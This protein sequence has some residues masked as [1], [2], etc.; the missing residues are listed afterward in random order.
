M[1]TTNDIAMVAPALEKYAQGP[2]AD[3]IQTKIRSLQTMEKTL[4]KL[5]KS[6]TGC[7]P[8]MECPILESLDREDL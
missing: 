1:Q 7:G 2:L 6:C 3:D 8:V 4:W 5:T